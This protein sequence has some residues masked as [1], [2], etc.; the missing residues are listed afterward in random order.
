M[1]SDPNLDMLPPALRMAAASRGAGGGSKPKIRSKSFLMRKEQADALAKVRCQP[2][3]DMA[4]EDARRKAILQRREENKKKRMQEE[5]ERR[6]QEQSQAIMTQVKGKEAD[7]PVESPRPSV[8]R[9]DADTQALKQEI[10]TLPLVAPGDSET[11]HDKKEHTADILRKKLEKVEKLLNTTDPDSKDYKKLNKKRDQY[12]QELESMAAEQEEEQEPEPVE[13]YEE[14]P[15]PEPVPPPKPVAPT[16]TAESEDDKKERIRQARLEEYRRKQAERQKEE[17]ETR[18]KAE[19]EAQFTILK[20]KL[21]KIEGMISDAQAKGDSAA[22]LLKKRNEYLVQ[23]DDFEEWQEEKVARREAEEEAERRRREKEE[24]QQLRQQERERKA[25]LEEERRRKAQEEAER[26]KKETEERLL[27]EKEEERERARRQEEEERRKQ[28]EAREARRKEEE[29]ER[30]LQEEQARIEA[31]RTAEE[32]A[33]VLRLQEERAKE[34]A[35]RRREEKED[36]ARQREEAAEA[37]RVQEEQEAEA[38]RQRELEQAQIEEEEYVDDEEELTE[39]ELQ[40]IEQEE[41]EHFLFQQEQAKLRAKEKQAREEAEEAERIARE[42]E[43]EAERKAQ[44]EAAAAEAERKAKEEEERKSA[45]SQEFMDRKAIPLPH[46]ANT[47]KILA[48]LETVEHHQAKLE[49]TLKQHGIAVSEEIPYDLAKEKIASIQQEMQSLATS[50][51]DQFVVQ[52]KYYALEEEMS[53]YVT[54]MMLT[55][56]WA[57]EQRAAEEKW[58]ASVEEENIVALRKLRRHMPVNIRNM[59]EDELSTMTTPNGKTLPK[60]FAKKFKRTNVLQLLRVNPEDLERMHPSLIEGLRSTG[61][62]LTERRALHEH[63][64]H[65]GARWEELQQD[66][67]VERKYSWFLSLKAKFKEMVTAYE[68]CVSQWG[69]AGSHRYAKRNDPPGSGCTLIGNQCPVKADSVISYDDDY[70]FTDEA[71]YEAS[72]STKASG[73]H[74]TGSLVSKSK[75]STKSSGS[76]EQKDKELMASI[77]ESLNLIEPESSIDSKLIRELFHAQKRALSLEKQLTQNNLSIPKE[78]ISYAVA[79]EKVTTL[80]EEIKE[81]AVK[82]GSTVDM[83]EMA[84]LEKEY[85]KLSD[86]LEKY[87]DALMLT[88][89]YALELIEKERQWE[90]NVKPANQEA[91]RNIRRHMPVNIKDLSEQD[92]IQGVTPNGK[93][94]PQKIVRKFKRTNILQLVRM[95]PSMIEPMHPSSLESMRSTGLLLSERRAL[96]EHL[97]ELGE[98]WKAASNDKMAERKWMWHES[99]RGKFKELATKYQQHI[100]QYGPPGSHTCSLIGKQCPI[101]ADMEIDYSVDYGFPAEAVYNVEQVKKSNLLTVEDL[102]RRKQEGDDWMHDTSANTPVPEVAKPP[103]AGL[104]ASIADRGGAAATSDPPKMGGGLMA[105]IAAKGGDDGDSGARPPKLAGGLMAAIASKG[106]GD[107]DAQPPK[108]GG[109]LMAAIAAKG[110]NAGNDAD[111]SAPKAPPKMGGGLLAAIQSKASS[112]DD[113]AA[114]SAPVSPPKQK[115]RMGGGLLAAITNRGKK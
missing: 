13:P 89:E 2:R 53:K 5:E 43:L 69:P 32:E 12:I 33:Q 35:Q 99:L 62:T 78:D 70:G 21:H 39:E 85:T 114:G 49:K 48:E 57:E 107:G 65:V 17:E 91:L 63:L 72:D 1:P 105:A 77:M 52:K 60:A 68:R 26:I 42:A 24:E 27:R 115:K 18:L 3:D 25:K 83:K 96:H 66:P 45:A 109:G 23:L 38:Q 61:L 44:E 55:D 47:K 11:N 14:E 102:E 10:H 56:E 46:S 101:K 93:Q 97:K 113:S 34:E 19:R 104:M 31:E 94:L 82:M 36:E 95:P 92:L 54:A 16:P 84:V 71:F 79:K 108:M 22:K 28:E 50:T 106:G 111:D 37:R 30:R 9:N 76:K 7:L 8:I 75:S 88:K 74:D 87:N 4:T 64:K 100:D 67:S 41:L 29:E 51:E 73:S 6:A 112:G 110:G 103:T 15:E 98:K 40:R 86:E 20:K 58:E 59:T 90:E 81:V 80:T